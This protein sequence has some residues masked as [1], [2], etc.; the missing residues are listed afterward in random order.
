MV[1]KEKAEQSPDNQK[2]V[3]GKATDLNKPYLKASWHTM[4]NNTPERVH[5]FFS[6]LTKD[7]NDNR[8]IVVEEHKAAQLH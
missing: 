2:F 8:S 3:V 6:I 1:K 5:P 4:T 7:N